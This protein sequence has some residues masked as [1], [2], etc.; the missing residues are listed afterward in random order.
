MGTPKV[1]SISSRATSGSTKI[2]TTVGEAVQTEPRYRIAI[3]TA[4]GETAGFVVVNNVREA[5]AAIDFL[6]KNNKGKA[7]FI[8]LDRLP[9]L[10]NHRVPIQSA[11]VIGWASNLVQFDGQHEKLFNFLFDETLLVNDVPT[12]LNIVN[13]YP[14]VRCITLEGEIVTG[15]G[16]VRGG[17]VRQDEGGHI[18]KKSQLEEFTADVRKLRERHE[19]ISSDLQKKIED[20]ENVNLK[21]LAEEARTIEQQKT[22]VEIRIAQIEFEKKRAQDNIERNDT[23]TEK[24]GQEIELLNKE[25]QTLSPSIVALE[26]RQ[27]EAEQQV[28]AAMSEVE[29]MDALWNEYSGVANEANLSVLA[30]KSEERSIVQEKE[31]TATTLQSVSTTFDQRTEEI[32]K[33]K[34]DIGSIAADLEAISA[35]AS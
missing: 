5:Y 23:E 24:L 25:L 29:T 15:S 1:Q 13:D 30:L 6:K 2:Q 3:E 14:A 28:G 10:P 19:H 22:S 9:N 20:L 27:A 4:L 8:C 17:S 26:Q 21:K 34:E 7:T 12:A 33:A 18:S 31:Y 11:G 16:V 32:F 35:N